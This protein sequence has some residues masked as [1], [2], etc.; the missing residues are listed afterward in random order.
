MCG[1]RKVRGIGPAAG[2]DSL[3]L[4]SPERYAWAVRVIDGGRFMLVGVKVVV[5]SIV[6]Y[7]KG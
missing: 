6:L 5:G 7:K 4:Y 2:Y 3:D 1:W